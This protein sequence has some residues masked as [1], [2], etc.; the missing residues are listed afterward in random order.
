MNTGNIDPPKYLNTKALMGYEMDSQVEVKIPGEN[1]QYNNINNNNNIDNQEYYD[2]LYRFSNISPT[3]SPTSIKKFHRNISSGMTSPS[4]ISSSRRNSISENENEEEDNEDD[5]IQIHDE[6][7]RDT[8]GRLSELSVGMRPNKLYLSVTGPPPNVHPDIKDMVL[9]EKPQWKL[10]QRCCFT[11]CKRR[12][13]Y[14]LLF[15]RR[16]H[17]RNC[18]DSVCGDHSRNYITLQ[19]LAY[20]NPVRVCNTCYTRYEEAHMNFEN[21]YFDRTS[22]RIFN[23]IK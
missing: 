9:L 6:K 1:N 14:G 18:G 13:G 8:I 5:N 20:S 2:G 22:F 3:L 15:T 16:H 11:S 23:G 17:C 12:F 7:G 19:H 21:F 10:K 4:D